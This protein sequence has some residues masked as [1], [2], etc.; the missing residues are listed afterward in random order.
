MA[1]GASDQLLI[2]LAQHVGF[3]FEE[4]RPLRVDPP[5]WRR[6]M[7]RV[8]LT[9]LAVHRAFAAELQEQLL[10]CV[11][12]RNDIEPTAEWLAEIETA[13]A[14]CD[15]LVALL[16]PKF[17]ESPWTD[18][19]IGYAMGRGVPTFAVS[20]GQDPHGFIPRFQAFNGQNKAP[21][22]LAREVFDVC[23]KHKQIGT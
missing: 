2:D 10:T 1:E 7:L 20:F 17:H 9:H 12:A 16:H 15:A 21:R 3:Q 19:E 18:Q 13:L 14:T 8:F 5:F 23:R 6:E 22:D 4:P 11:V